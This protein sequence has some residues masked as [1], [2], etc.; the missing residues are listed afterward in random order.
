MFR[1]GGAFFSGHGVLTRAQVSRPIV[2]KCAL[3]PMYSWR[4]LP[5][6]EQFLPV[7]GRH[8]G[9]CLS[10][11]LLAE[12]TYRCLYCAKLEAAA[13]RRLFPVT[14]CQVSSTVC[15]SRCMLVK[16][17]VCFRDQFIAAIIAR[18]L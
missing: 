3:I 11:V 9:H 6:L 12:R 13:R 10:L 1:R 17:S 14:E 5:V 2:G 7:I 8:D 16:F 4:Q 15:T 18:Y